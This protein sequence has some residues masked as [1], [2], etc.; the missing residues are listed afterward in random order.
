[1]RS[2]TIVTSAH[3]RLLEI[4][5]MNPTEIQAKATIVAALIAT[6]AVDVPSMPKHLQAGRPDQA[7]IRLRELTDYVYHAIVGDTE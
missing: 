2:F 4:A 6:H 7:A 3:A 5:P 1:M